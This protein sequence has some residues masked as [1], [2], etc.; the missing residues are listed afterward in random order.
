M[1]KTKGGKKGG[2]R[3]PVREGCRTSHE[4]VAEYA[5]LGEQ[6]TMSVSGGFTTN[7]L[8]SLMNT[9]LDQFKRASTVAQGYQ[10]YRIK[11]IK[12]SVKPTFDTYQ[13]VGGGPATTR[14]SPTF[15]T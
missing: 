3:D 7:N 8:Y 12:V 10:H 4:N 5:S 1:G 9:S 14:Q 2:K 13:T 11:Y 6:R 15:T